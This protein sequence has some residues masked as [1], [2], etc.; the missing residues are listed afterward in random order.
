MGLTGDSVQV[1]HTS[2]SKVPRPFPYLVVSRSALVTVPK[3]AKVHFNYANFLKD[4]GRRSEA[5]QFYRTAIKYVY[6]CLCHI[7]N[8]SHYLVST[9]RCLVST[10]CCLVSTRAESTA[11]A[12]LCRL[13]PDHA[14][15]HNNLG[16][17]LSGKEAELHFLEAVHHNPQ[18]YKAYYNLARNLQ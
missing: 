10:N 12:M 17:L 5:I 2:P 14:V 9:R 3:N 1:S 11:H 6:V 8:A 13:A 16:S 7:Y 4:S 15:S 18:H